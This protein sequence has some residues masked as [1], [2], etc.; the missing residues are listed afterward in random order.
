MK[1]NNIIIFFSYSST[2]KR[3]VKLLKVL[4]KDI[5]ENDIIQYYEYTEEND[6]KNASTYT[7]IMGQ[8]QNSTIFISILSHNYL[9]SPL[10]CWEAGIALLHRTTTCKIDTIAMLPES[11]DNNLLELYH[12]FDAQFKF[13]VTGIKALIERI[14][15]KD[16]TNKFDT[17]TIPHELSNLQKTTEKKILEKIVAQ[18]KSYQ[19]KPELIKKII[20][21]LNSA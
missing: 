20:E 2:D 7:K 21:G 18:N 10:C 13:N 14:K 12:T 6:A 3:Y 8:I 17:V 5:D 9:K 1:R 16:K 15:N 11:E 19:K 4:L